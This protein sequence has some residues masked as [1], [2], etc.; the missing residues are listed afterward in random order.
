M[1][2]ICHHNMTNS[3]SKSTVHN[4]DIV[5]F[6]FKHRFHADYPMPIFTED[7]LRLS[8]SKFLT[9]LCTNHVTNDF[10]TDTVSRQLSRL[11]PSRIWQW[12]HQSLMFYLLRLPIEC[13]RI[14][15]IN[16]A[17][18]NVLKNFLPCCWSHFSISTART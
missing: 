17:Y 16:T 9:F 12:M 2:C 18:E 5:Y 10:T 14:L 1:I 8:A 13:P 3:M 6:I 15:L 7:F 11:H 4:G